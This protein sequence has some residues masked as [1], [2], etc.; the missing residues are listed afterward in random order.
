M[1]KS[2]VG[3]PQSVKPNQLKVGDTILINGET[4]QISRIIS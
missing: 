2:F 1:T 4:A 3:Q